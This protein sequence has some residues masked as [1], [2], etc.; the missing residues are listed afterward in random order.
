[1][2]IGDIMLVFGNK[3]ICYNSTAIDFAYSI[4]SAIGEKIIA[5]K[6]DGKIIPLNKE[7]KNTQIC[8]HAFRKLKYV[9]IID[10]FLEEY[11][12]SYLSWNAFDD[13]LQQQ[14]KSETSTGIEGNE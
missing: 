7:L 4:H 9:Q 6:A 14:K 3:A 11:D 5:A 1:M 13:A 8:N 2:E 10:S 12:I